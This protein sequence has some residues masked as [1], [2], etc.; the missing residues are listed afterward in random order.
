MVSGM[1]TRKVTVTLDEQ[2]VEEIKALVKAGSAK[3]V[4]AFVQH[5][6]SVALDDY[7][8]WDA[9]LTDALEATGGPIT[10]EEQAWADEV[11]RVE[12]PTR[13]SKPRRGAA[14]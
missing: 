4:S 5:A 6:C 13:K 2:Q 14:A 8:G 9:M 11:L 1:A 12:K 10:A 3:N 7:A